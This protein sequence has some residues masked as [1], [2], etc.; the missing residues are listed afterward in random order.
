MTFR[1][2]IIVPVFNHADGATKLC[3]KVA[4]LGVALFLVNDGSDD[5]CSA[6]LRHLGECHDW[7][8]I[9]EHET[10][11]GKGRAVLSG[12][13]AALGAGFSHALQIDAD[14]QHNVE[15]IPRFFSWAKENPSAIVV[16]QPLFD[17]S[18]P[19]GRLIARYLTHVFVWIETISFAIKDSMCG[20]RVYPLAPVIRL[21]NTTRLGQ[22]MDFDPEVL[23][24]LH[25]MQI[26][27]ITL[28]TK[29]VY[30]IGG[31]SHFLPWTD[32]WLISCMHTKLVF[33]MI[34][35]LPVILYRK[36]IGQKTEAKAP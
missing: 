28:K 9:I 23:V 7:V 36:C 13:R 5:E 8:H 24:R 21:A 6:I 22:R 15:D 33:G 25:W 26:Q 3:S 30:P 14:G 31:Q 35:R 4:A 10:N 19:M 20:F 34:F 32:N 17:E 16:G 12:L 29:V 2:C 18:V 11:C 1:A 27:I